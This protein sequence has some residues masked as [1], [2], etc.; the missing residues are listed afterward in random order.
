MQNWNS[1]LPY[2]IDE[3]DLIC[4]RLAEKEGLTGMDLLTTMVAHRVEPL[5]HRSYLICQMG[6][7][8][9]PCRLSTKELGP[10]HVARRVDLISAT[11]MDEGEWQWGKAPY[12][13]QHQA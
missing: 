7:R 1:D 6:D 4:S 5:Q 10:V 3:V 2:P 13:R 11:H 12:D 9:A 8:R